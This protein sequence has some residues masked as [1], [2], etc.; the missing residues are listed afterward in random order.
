MFPDVI[1]AVVLFIMSV[2][3]LL[4]CTSRATL[5]NN[6]TGEV[7]EHSDPDNIYAMAVRMGEDITG[8]L[9]VGDIQSTAALCQEAQD[10]IQGFYDIDD[11][12]SAA[13]YASYLKKYIHEHESELGDMAQ[14]NYIIRGFIETVMKAPESNYKPSSNQSDTKKKSG[15]MNSVGMGM[16]EE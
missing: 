14:Q 3:M 8:M 7:V 10:N 5:D 2:C 6:D 15:T 4:S 9:Q 16:A 13:V 12:A 1:M 11:N